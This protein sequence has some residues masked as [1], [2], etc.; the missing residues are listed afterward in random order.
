MRGG[1][2]APG[3]TQGQSTAAGQRSQEHTDSITVILWEQGL[4]IA[5]SKPLLEQMRKRR[6]RE[7]SALLEFARLLS[8]W[9]QARTQI[10]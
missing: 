8:D 5:R 7:R 2:V 9:T 10:S 1:A 3:P 4:L 6:L